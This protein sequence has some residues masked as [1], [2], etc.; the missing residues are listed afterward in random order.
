MVNG[1]TLPTVPD[2]CDHP[3]HLF[4]LLLPSSERREA[5]L[6]HLR[7]RGVQAVFHYVPLHLSE[8]GR[9]FGAAHGDCPVAEDVSMRLARLPL[10][11]DATAAEQ[12]QVVTAIRQF[13]C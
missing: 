9:R 5:F 10:S 4:Y 1:V 2:G 13:Q 6:R 11:T 12:E 8:M 3:A 7:D